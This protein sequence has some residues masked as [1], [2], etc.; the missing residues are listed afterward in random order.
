MKPQVTLYTRAGCCLCVD[1]K[2]VI[3]AARQRVDFDYSEVDIDTDAELVR[4]YDDEVP[5]IAINRRKAFKYKV[6]MN[7][8]LKKLAASI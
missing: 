8:F 6:E 5:V 1:A 4:L 3:A 7:Q 2:K